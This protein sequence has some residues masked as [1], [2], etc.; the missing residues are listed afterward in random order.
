MLTRFTFIAAFVALAAMAMS[1][2]CC[3]TGP[4]IDLPSQQQIAVE[5]PT[6][7]MYASLTSAGSAFR[8]AVSYNGEPTCRFESYDLIVYNV[9]TAASDISVYNVLGQRVLHHSTQE[10]STLRIPFENESGLYFVEL[11]DARNG[12]VA[13][14]KAVKR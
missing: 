4:L 14:M 2:R 7:V 9:P 12:V 13:V 3:T 11:R 6:E 5:A 8:Q 1:G 10:Q